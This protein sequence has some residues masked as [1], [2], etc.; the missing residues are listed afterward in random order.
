MLGGCRDQFEAD[1]VRRPVSEVDLWRDAIVDLDL[2]G[3]DG[4]GDSFGATMMPRILMSV[5]PAAALAGAAKP[6]AN[7]KP[8][9]YGL[10]CV[11]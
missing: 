5:S 2:F 1:S 11:I 7:T 9:K 8:A 3:R 4:R 6:H 10:K